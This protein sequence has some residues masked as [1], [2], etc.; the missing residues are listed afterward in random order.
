MPLNLNVSNLASSSFRLF[1]KYFMVCI[2][3]LTLKLVRATQYI[4]SRSSRKRPLREFD[5]VVV[6]RAGRLQ[7]YALVSNPMV[8]Q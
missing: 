4:Y 5:K 3:R 8:K 2:Y 6:N 7:E 1:Q